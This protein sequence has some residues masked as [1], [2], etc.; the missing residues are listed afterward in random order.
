MTEK[1][2]VELTRKKESYPKPDV[3]FVFV[4][5]HCA[6]WLEQQQNNNNN[7]QCSLAN[8]GRPLEKP[9]V[10]SHLC[11]MRIMTGLYLSQTVVSK[12][13]HIWLTSEITD[14]VKGIPIMA[15]KMQNTRPAI[16]FGAMFP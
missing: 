15:N 14:K 16:V 2:V 10:T 4:C 7:L 1:S 9:H 5:W 8:S 13:A 11:R 12:V 6:K 3:L